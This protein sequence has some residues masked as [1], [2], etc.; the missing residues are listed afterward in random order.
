VIEDPPTVDAQNA[1]VLD[2]IA[3]ACEELEAIIIFL[4][5]AV[6]VIASWIHPSRPISLGVF[7][8]TLHGAF[9]ASLAA[10]DLLAPESAQRD[11]RPGFIRPDATATMTLEL[12]DHTLIVARLRS[13]G[14][15]TLFSSKLPLGLARAQAREVL[16][17]LSHELPLGNA[18]TSIQ[19]ISGGRKRSSMAMPAVRPI[20][21]MR[22]R[23]MRPSGDHAAAEHASASHSLASHSLASHSLASHS[24]ASQSPA[25][26]EPAPDT[27]RQ[28]IPVTRD[29]SQESSAPRDRARRILDE[30]AD[31]ATDPHVVLVRVG[32]R[33]GLGLEPFMDPESLSAEA[34]VLLETAAEDILGLDRG[35]LKERVP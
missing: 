1:V 2:G 20:E 33:T 16:R 12:Q 5:D 13:F 30:L 28:S 26:D 31:R 22:P 17:N 15:A 8:P 3:A 10:G 7:T 27:G 4:V 14:V 24:P 19:V 32:L 29:P 11:Q 34:I 35:A 25:E 6:H 21:E 9:A 23:A 18:P